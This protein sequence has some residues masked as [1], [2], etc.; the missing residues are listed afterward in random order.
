MKDQLNNPVMLDQSSS[1][2]RDCYIVDADFRGFVCQ[3]RSRKPAT[4]PVDPLVVGQGSPDGH[5]G[6]HGIA[7]YARYLDDHS[8]VVQQQLI[9]GS[10]VA[11]QFWLID[12]DNGRGSGVFRVRVG[13][14]EGLSHRQ[15]D[16]LGLK[17]SDADFR[18]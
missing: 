11:R 9:S 8:P 5:D 16:A 7:F 6:M 12:A 14:R 3:A 15:V 18:P 10:A 1:G 13:K 2:K 17:A 4:A